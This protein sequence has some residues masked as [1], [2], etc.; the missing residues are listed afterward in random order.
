MNNFF[1]ILLIIALA[2]GAGALLGGGS[3]LS[4]QQNA[5]AS[6][7][8]MAAQLQNTVT[9][10][11]AQLNGQA[12]Q[13]GVALAY[14]LTIAAS[15]R[16]AQETE[17]AAV[18]TSIAV[19]SSI[20]AT[21]TAEPHNAALVANRTQN[22]MNRDDEQT[23][24]ILAFVVI[25]SLIGLAIWGGIRAKQKQIKRG[26]NGLVPAYEDAGVIV[27]PEKELGT[28]QIIKPSH[29]EKFIWIIYVLY[30]LFWQ[31]Q[32][33]DLSKRPQVRVVK[34]DGNATADH[35]LSAHQA[36]Q[37]TLTANALMQPWPER[38]LLSTFFQRGNRVDE[39][40]GRLELIR[41]VPGTLPVPSSAALLPAP[42]IEIS[43]DLDEGRLIATEI[44]QQRLAEPGQLAPSPFRSEG[45]KDIEENH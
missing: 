31:H 7:T 17:T 24:G 16:T 12:T 14:T 22:E 37:P 5:Q 18:R 9:A 4:P 26:A 45:E 19:S 43:N 42:I 38:G 15:T 2:L 33:P 6:I 23:L 3:S 28:I 29:T 35:L 39:R 32:M 8:V 27:N 1:V 34:H 10:G 36:L 25:L 44:G 30:K 41:P 40:Q 13:T 20:Y 11:N 21:R